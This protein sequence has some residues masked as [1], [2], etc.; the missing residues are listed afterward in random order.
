MALIKCPECGK[1]ISDQAKSC[2]GCGKPIEIKESTTNRTNKR[3]IILICGVIIVLLSVLVITLLLVFRKTPLEKRVEKC[4][5]ILSDMEGDYEFVDAVCFKRSKNACYLQDSSKIPEDTWYL[6][7]IVYK[8]D[9]IQYAGFN[10]DNT[11]MGDGILDEPAVLDMKQTSSEE[12]NKHIEDMF[13]DTVVSWLIAE[14][15][16][17]QQGLNSVPWTESDYEDVITEKQANDYEH[18]M[19]TVE[20]K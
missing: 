2:P 13:N 6:T 16:A 7:L 10:Y 9:Y 1:E 8:K 20:S 14:Y 18:C 5:Q 3:K 17:F 19:I 15:D 11:Y 12:K 4:R